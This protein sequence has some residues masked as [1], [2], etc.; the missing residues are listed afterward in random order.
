MKIPR[1]FFYGALGILILSWLVFGL[2][3]RNRTQPANIPVLPE[4][5]NEISTPRNPPAA[6]HDGNPAE[7]EIVKA[8]TTKNIPPQTTQSVTLV[9][10]MRNAGNSTARAA[11]ETEL[12]ALRQGDPDLVASVI[13]FDPAEAPQIVDLL[14]AVPLEIRKQYPTPERLVAFL[15]MGGQRMESIEVLAETPPRSDIVVQHVRYKFL[16]D[17]TIHE[18]DFVFS[19]DAAGWKSFVPLALI[20]R[21]T[22]AIR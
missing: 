1:S 7:D 11:L 18:E 22:E 5:R 14:S 12:Y 19:R 2:S 13:T 17:P 9:A 10:T 21:L 15:F 4:R 6:P 20:E 16:D 3:R 8:N